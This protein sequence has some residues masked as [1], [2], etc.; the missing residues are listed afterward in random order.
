M[1]DFE[2]T[3]KK[4]FISYSHDT[5]K[6]TNRVLALSNRLRDEGVDCQVDQY[7]ESPPQGWARWM[8]DQIEWAD[9][10]LVICTETYLRRFRGKEG[11]GKG[12][13]ATWEG[14][15]ISQEIYDAHTQNTRFIPI[16][17][18]LEEAEHIPTILR[19]GKHYDI[20]TEEGY[21]ELYRRLTGQPLVEKPPLGPRR[22]RE[23]KTD[24]FEDATKWALLVGINE[25]ERADV[26]PL[27][28][29]VNDVRAFQQELPR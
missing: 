28:F 18:A 12:K 22:A 29:A 7:E 4:V 2:F 10:V 14:A 17:F 3:P 27:S 11:Q 21:E 5:R 8:E 13:G 20:S 9:F 24:F 23:R 19:G 26:T 16:V 6:H 15:I 25:Y 1:A